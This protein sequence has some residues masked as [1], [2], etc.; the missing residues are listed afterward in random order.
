MNWCE[1][2]DLIYSIKVIN[3]K[4]GIW[5][6]LTGYDMSTNDPEIDD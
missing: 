6:K 2:I 1:I 5:Y 4:D 3:P